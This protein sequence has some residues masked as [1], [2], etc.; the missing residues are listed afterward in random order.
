MTFKIELSELQKKAKERT[1]KTQN[2]EYDLETLVKKIDRRVIK[3]DPDY[4]RKHRW[5]DGASSKLIESL[6]LNIPIP[7]V[8]ISLDIDVDE[9]IDEDEQYRY[10]VIDGQQRLTAIY[11]YLKN[12]YPLVDL[13]V[14]DNLN[15]AFYKDLPPFLVRRLEE[16]TLKCLRIDSTL[17]QQVKY[18]IFERLNTG[19]LKLESQELRNAIYRGPFRDLIKELSLNTDFTSA[20]NLT[21][22]KKKKMEDQELILRF[23]A[24][25]YKD[26][27][28][29]YKKGFKEF[30]NSSMQDFNGSDSGELQEMNDEFLRVFK[31]IKES[32]IENP[33]SKWKEEGGKLKLS[34]KFNASVFDSVCRIFMKT[35]KK[36]QE[37]HLKDMFLSPDYFDACTGSVN[38]ISKIKTRMEK[39]EEVA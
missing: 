20:C 14:L 38:D 19:A 30:L 22:S 5:E 11:N 1:V 13:E 23:F 36:I 25:N 9:E 37:N 39:A 24:L 3:L 26:G 4:Q 12:Q 16:R 32:G 17:D 21:E 35:N 31:K 6:I 29:K 7:Y 10:S 28:T 33:F 15:G 18:D 8:Y 2:I 27:Y 34:S